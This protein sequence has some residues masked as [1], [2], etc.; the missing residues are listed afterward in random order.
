ML[1]KCKECNNDVSTKALACPKCGAIVK[2]KSRIGKAIGIGFIIFLFLFIVEISSNNKIPHEADKMSAWI[3]AK[4]FVKQSLISPT[5]A[6]FGSVFSD[7]QD[8]DE[9]VTDL[10]GGK[11]QIKGWVDAENIFGAKKV[12]NYFICDLEYLGNSQWKLINLEYIQE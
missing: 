5:T 4:K 12:R 6:S 9:I 7:Y 11:Y 1:S 3:M 2:K 10:G 8:P